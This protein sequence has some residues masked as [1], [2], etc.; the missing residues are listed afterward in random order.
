MSF[1]LPAPPPKV[2]S[3]TMSA[4]LQADSC[5]P[6]GGER[7]C[8]IARVSPH[9]FE[10]YE[11]PTLV[12]VL[13]IL[14]DSTDSTG[15]RISFLSSEPHGCSSPR[16]EGLILEGPG[17]PGTKT[18]AVVAVGRTQVSEELLFG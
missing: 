12:R 1:S 3:S 4:V 13:C 2:P 5:C 10:A 17:T 7:A 16:L 9:P 15:A 14:V 8:L 6:L 11:K 18:T